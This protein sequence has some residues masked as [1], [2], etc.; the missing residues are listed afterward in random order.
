MLTTSSDSSPLHLELRL[1]PPGAP[2]LFSS[3]HLKLTTALS[4]GILTPLSIPT[5][6][7]FMLST[8]SEQFAQAL[9][10]LLRWNVLDPEFERR[11]DRTPVDSLAPHN[12]SAT[13]TP[14]NA[15]KALEMVCGWLSSR[16]A[17]SLPCS[18]GQTR[19]SSRPAMT[20]GPSDDSTHTP[21]R[22]MLHLF[23]LDIFGCSSSAAILGLLDQVAQSILFRTRLLATRLLKCTTDSPERKTTQTL[24]VSAHCI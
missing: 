15:P 21:R 14:V 20:K 7:Q 11:A 16:N 8:L 3:H 4:Q 6:M 24:I 23:Y 17:N 12:A 19:T 22:T 5:V 18:T 9:A 10:S 13:S 2:P 1:G